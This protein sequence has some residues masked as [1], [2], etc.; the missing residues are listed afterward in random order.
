MV[1]VLRLVVL[2]TVV[3]VL[4]RKSLIERRAGDPHLIWNLLD[5]WSGP[6][7]VIL[8]YGTLHRLNIPLV[9]CQTWPLTSLQNLT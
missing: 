4:V 6:C 5:T 7:V 3:K 1:G 8:I 9:Q 2:N